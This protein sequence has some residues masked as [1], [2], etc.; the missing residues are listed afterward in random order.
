LFLP[1]TI[2]YSLSTFCDAAQTADYSKVGIGARVLGMGRSF[3]ALADDA[4]AVFVNPAGIIFKRVPSLTS[5]FTNLS[6]D[7]NYSVFGFVSPTRFGSIGIGYLTSN[8][9]GLYTTSVDSNGIINANSSFNFSSSQMTLSYSRQISKK[10]FCGASLKFINKSFSN[11]TGGNGSGNNMDLGLIY[12]FNKATNFG[13]NFQNILASSMNWGTGKSEVITSK[14][15]LGF[16]HR[17]R[18]QLLWLL[19]WEIENPSK[20]TLLNSGI[21]WTPSKNFAF[22]A[23]LTQ[24]A[25]PEGIIGSSITL[26]LGL[27]LGRISFDYGYKIDSQLSEANYGYFSVSLDIGEK[28]EENKTIITGNEI[29]I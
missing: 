24:D 15:K 13:L 1:S 25:R 12:R 29:G 19:D 28:K 18:E 8:T 9:A 16:S 6:G 21:E 14:T 10:L 20:P 7:I 2:H 4:N 3:V 26:G 23:G 5:V 22:R 27:N 17:L 11:Q